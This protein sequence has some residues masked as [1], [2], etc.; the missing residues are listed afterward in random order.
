MLTRKDKL[1]HYIQPATQLGVEIGALDR[2]IVSR[3]MGQIRYVDH[4]TT[5]EL[6]VKYADPS[7]QIDT[8]KIVDVDYI[9]GEK[10]LGELLQADAPVDYLIASHVIEHVPDLIGWLNEI[11]SILKPGGILSLAVP[12]KRRCFDYLRNQT[13]TG[14]VI[15]A[16]LKQRKKPAPGQI[17]DDVA[18]QVSIQGKLFS[19]DTSYID[20]SQL[21]HSSSVED[22][23]TVAKTAFTT[24]E[25]R[26]S[27]C[28]VFTPAS[29]F[30][31][32]SDLTR[33][34]LF[35]FDVAKFYESSGNEFHV[36]LRSTDKPDQ[37]EIDQL[38][39]SLLESEKAE[40]TDYVLEKKQLDFSAL[41]EAEK[42]K[43][44]GEYQQEIGNLK[45]EIRS[46]ENT[47]FWKMRNIWLK[48]KKQLGLPL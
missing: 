28:W 42:A 39:A 44:V 11:H 23:L 32:L 20:E 31:M 34:G 18:S 27:H 12:D 22:A 16:Y 26:D 30:R 13:R 6:R 10:G 4:A 43:I 45:A 7:T 38:A 15:D 3:D 29:F 1:L 35:H 37:V 8:S 9:W 24:G 36:S 5:E 14:E 40:L 2:P 17:F 41:L 47:K 48:G 21:V 33:L 46:M 19:W 25:Y